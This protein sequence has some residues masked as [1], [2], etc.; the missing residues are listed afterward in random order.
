MC[1]FPPKFN[2]C[3]GSKCGTFGPSNECC[4]SRIRQAGNTCSETCIR[5]VS[6]MLTVCVCSELERRKCVLP[7]KVFLELHKSTFRERNVFVFQFV[8]V[9]VHACRFINFVYCMRK[10]CLA[11][12]IYWV[13]A[14][15]LGSKLTFENVAYLWCSTHTLPHYNYPQTLRLALDFRV[16]EPIS[17]RVLCSRGVSPTRVKYFLVPCTKHFHTWQT[18]LVRIREHYHKCL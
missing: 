3:D 14:H 15:I 7:S 11:S 12:C 4:G 6:K 8:M 18:F 10:P 17:S 2:E 13:R 1:I 5:C 9:N 16:I